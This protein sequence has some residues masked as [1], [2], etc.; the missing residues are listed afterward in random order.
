MS[1][2][3]RLHQ[4]WSSYQAIADHWKIRLCTGDCGPLIVGDHELGFANP[5]RGVI[6]F[7]E[8]VVTRAGIRRFLML[9]ASILHSHNRGQPEWQKLY[10]Q[11]T[12]AG[13]AA[14]KMGVR[15]PR[16]FSML[17]RAKTYRLIRNEEVPRA[18]REWAIHRD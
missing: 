5:S 3:R 12:W 2:G 4:S 18:V 7:R 13:Q 11:N 6:H 16:K 1:S 8:R 9:I 15:V 14:I 17:D 10:E